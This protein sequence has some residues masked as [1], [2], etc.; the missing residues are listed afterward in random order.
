MQFKYGYLISVYII[1]KIMGSDSLIK[2]GWSNWNQGVR[3]VEFKFRSFCHPCFENMF[4]T[5]STFYVHVVVLVCYRLLNIDFCKERSRIVQV[6][7]AC[8]D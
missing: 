2:H 8:R 1:Y 4:P 5:F 3:A 6:V 7:T